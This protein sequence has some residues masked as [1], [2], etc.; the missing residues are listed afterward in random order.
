[1]DSTIQIRADI[2]SDKVYEYAEAMEAKADFPPVDLFESKGGYYIG[3]GWHRILAAQKA[4]IITIKAEVHK[5]GRSEAL[6]FALSANAQHGLPRT[7]ADKR[8]AV[9]VALKEYPDL[10]STQIAKLC[11]VSDEM[12]RKARK[13]VPTVGASP[14]HTDTLGRQQ[15]ATK[16][17]RTEVGRESHSEESNTENEN[18]GMSI[19]QTAPKKRLPK[20]S[21]NVGMEC[22]R[23]A[24]VQLDKIHPKDVSREAALREAIKYCNER[25]EKKQ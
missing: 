2:D 20:Q 13:V 6:K 10:P 1:M 12:V 9:E 16:S 19:T 17:R 24:K 4:G 11:A 25:L 5:G 7:N 18:E 15:P 23:W 3:D 21:L 8:R 22:W 14:T